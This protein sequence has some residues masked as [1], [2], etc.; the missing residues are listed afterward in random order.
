MGGMFSPEMFN[1]FLAD[2]YKHLITEV[3]VHLITAIINY[4]LYAYDLILVSDSVEGLHKLLDGLFSFSKKIIARGTG[5][6]G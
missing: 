2:L 3:G 4:I 6:F 1:M 5:N